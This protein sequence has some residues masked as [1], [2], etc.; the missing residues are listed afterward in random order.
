[1]QEAEKTAADILS[2][3]WLE[4]IKD[5][6]GCHYITHQVENTWMHGKLMRR[7]L[8]NQKNISL[9]DKLRVH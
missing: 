8:L 3:E 7:Q 6:R 2:S 9:H 4:E 5:E 1:M